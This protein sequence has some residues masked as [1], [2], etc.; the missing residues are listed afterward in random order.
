MSKVCGGGRG[1]CCCCCCFEFGGC[2]WDCDWDV[3]V[4]KEV[5]VDCWVRAI[6]SRCSTRPSRI[7][8]TLWV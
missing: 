6:L 7:L 2:G 8:E 3:E 5:E 1:G 4:S